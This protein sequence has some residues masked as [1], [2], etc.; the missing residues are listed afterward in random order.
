M[1]NY[2]SLV[3]T[4]PSCSIPNGVNNIDI[5]AMMTNVQD[6]TEQTDMPHENL[7]LAT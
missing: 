7:N 5:A 6:Y 4:D 1:I 2:G 3:S